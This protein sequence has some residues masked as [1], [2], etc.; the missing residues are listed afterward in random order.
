MPRLKVLTIAEQVAKHLREEIMSGRWGETIPGRNELAKELGVNGKTVESALRLLEKEKV[1]IPQGAGKPRQIGRVKKI[2]KTPNLRV[3]LLLLDKKDRVAHYMIELYH[4]L[5]EAGYIPFYTDKSITDLG[6][7]NTERLAD[8]VKQTKTDTWIISSGS[9]SFIEWFSVSEVPA[10]ALFG[11]RVGLPIAAVGPD[12]E[13]AIL[14][15]TDRLLELGHRRISLLCRKQRRLPQP[16]LS[17]R[18]FLRR[19]EKANIQTSKFNLPDWKESKEGFAALLESLFGPTPPTALIVDEVFL[20]N[21][22]YYYLTSKG[23]HIPQDVSLICT[24]NDPGFDW[25]RPSVAHFDW[26]H[27]PVVRQVVRWVNNV[28][29]GKKDLKQV[30]TSAKFVEGETIAKAKAR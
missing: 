15:A 26:D 24:D 3:A 18:A 9:R 14:A 8:Y 4:L 10:F 2:K 7:D 13:A 6:L 27:L 28:S 5:E 17:E 16:G 1:L 12:K 21:A 19:L 29:Q 11:R 30:L 23:L 22:T 25:C 20:F